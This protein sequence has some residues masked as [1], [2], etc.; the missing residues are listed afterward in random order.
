MAEGPRVVRSD[1]PSVAAS[2]LFALAT[3]TSLR[4]LGLAWSDSPTTAQ[5]SANL[6]Q[7]RRDY[8]GG[9]TDEWIE[10]PGTFVHTDW[11]NAG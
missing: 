9:H 6:I 5:G 7:A 8:F 2:E 11:V 4:G 10:W 1:E 3:A